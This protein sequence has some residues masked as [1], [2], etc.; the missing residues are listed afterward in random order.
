[1]NE[2]MNN[3]EN[4]VI[5]DKKNNSEFI[6][7]IVRYIVGSIICIISLLVFLGDDIANGLWIMLFGLSIMP[8]IYKHKSFANV[9]KGMIIVSQ[10]FVPLIILFTAILIFSN[11]YENDKKNNDSNNSS[12]LEHETIKENDISNNIAINIEKNIA[13]AN[14]YQ[15]VKVDKYNEDKYTANIYL[16]QGYSNFDI[17]TKVANCGLDVINSIKRY[18]LE[19]VDK[20]I[21]QYNIFYY[22]S[23]SE[24]IYKTEYVNENTTSLNSITLIDNNNQIN[25]ITKEQIDLYLEQQRQQYLE[26]E[27]K[28]K[29]EQKQ[30]ELESKYDIKDTLTNIAYVYYQNEARGNKEY[31]GKRIMTTATITGISVDQSVLF[32]TGVSIHLKE[33]GAKYRLVCNNEKGISGITDVNRGDTITVIGKMNTMLSGSL[34]MDDC[35]IIK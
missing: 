20:Y 33:D 7:S 25:T 12:S 6:L 8:F 17:I 23:N 34:L 29:E 9:D 10:I 28:R 30:R 35:E 13:G 18:H 15:D 11:I 1:M 26:E 24:L 27:A 2:R 31:F 22:N 14:K 16:K 5:N 3:N 32:N 21:Y 4:K 19:D